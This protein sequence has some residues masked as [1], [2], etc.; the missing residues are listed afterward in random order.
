MFRRAEQ[1]TTSHE[2]VQPIITTRYFRGCSDYSECAA[3]SRLCRGPGADPHP[4]ARH[5]TRGSP[6]IC[7]VA[8]HA[9]RLA[10]YLLVLPRAGG[11]EL[12]DLAVDP[13]WRR[14]GVGTHL[15]GWLRLPAGGGLRRAGPDVDR[16]GCPRGGHRPALLPAVARV[17]GPA[18]L[19][20][21]VRPRG[22]DNPYGLGRE[23]A[24]GSGRRG[25]GESVNA[26]SP[27]RPPAG[28]ARG[29]NPTHDIGG[30]PISRD[31]VLAIEY[32]CR[33]GGIQRALAAH[34]LR[35]AGPCG[36]PRFAPRDRAR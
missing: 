25:E 6:T 20:G 3:I 4:I 28:P 29:G 15:M 18:R 17:P 1:P 7:V 12:V 11:L 2:P 36:Y 27:I 22:R 24:G 10:G 26:T 14:R 33:D 21:E 30:A 34:P 8:E 9:G 5:L 16:R 32:G 35:R 19:D 31:R 13:A 23:A